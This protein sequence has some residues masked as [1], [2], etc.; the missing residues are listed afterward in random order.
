MQPNSA[1]QN[2]ALLS[3]F[4]LSDYPLKHVSIRVPWHD[5]GWN[6]TVCNAPHL[7][8]A[9]AKLRRIANG[10][11]DAAEMSIAGKRLIDLPR[12]DWPCC[13]DESAAFMSPFEFSRTKTHPFAIRD[14][15]KHLRPTPQ[16]F[17]AFSAGAIPYRWLMRERIDHLRQQLDLD[18]DMSREPSLNYQTPWWHE[19]NNQAALLNGFADHLLPNDS[20]CLFYAKHLPFVEGAV[21]ALIGVGRITG[22]GGITEYE[23]AS[24]GMR[25]M[26]WERPVQHS[27]R[28]T[29]VA[30]FL[31]P[32]HEIYGRFADDPNL[33][34]E[35]YTAHAPPEHWELFSYGS[36]LVSHD[37]AISTLLSIDG[38]LERIESDLGIST[39]PQR[40]W[41]QDELVRLWKV[42]GPFPGLGAVLRAFGLSRGLFV[43]QALQEIAGENAD[44]WPYA[45]AAFQDPSAVL[46]PEL[47]TDIGEL[48]SAWLQLPDERRRFLQLLARFELTVDQAKSLYDRDAR[49]KKGWA[50]EDR[51][52]LENPYR[53]Y[54]VSRFDWEG[55]SV[56]TVDR[57]VFPEQIVRAEHPLN[58]PS[59]LDSAVDP[60]RVRALTIS[61]LEASAELGH[62][63]GFPGDLAG[64][65]Q[66]I[67]GQPECPATS[68]N[69]SA[70]VPEMT[71]EVVAVDNGNESALQLGRYRTIGDLVRRQVL[72]RVKG[73]RHVVSANW[74]EL[75]A[76]KF[77]PAQDATEIRAQKEKAAALSELAESRFTALAGPAGSGK[78]SVLDILCSQIQDEDFLLLAPT[79]RARVRLQELAGNSGYFA[80]TVAQFLIRCGRY[81][82]R[83]GRYHLS[84][85]PK[86]SGYGTVIVDEASMLTEDML[87]GIFD[88]LTGVNRF[89]LIGDPAQLPPI[90]A[91]RPFFDIIAKLRPQDNE[92]KFPRVSEGYAELTVERRQAGTDRPDLLLARWFGAASPTPGDDDI[93]SETE[94][95]HPRLRFV[96]WEKPEDFHIKLEEVLG[97]ELQLSA[98]DEVRS[99]NE[100]LGA[101][102]KGD[103]DYFNRNM[104]VNKV[105]AWQILSPLR[106]MP[107]G[108]ENINRQIH[109][110]FRADYLELASRNRQRQIP[111]PMG[112][113]RIV[114]GDKVINVRNHRR[115][116]IYP[117]NGHAFKYLA[118]GEVG[119]AVGQWRSKNMKSAPWTLK[120]E[121]ASQPGYTYD[122]SS[123]DFS[124][125]SE[126]TL[127]L[128]YG[129]TV[130]KAQG[131]QFKVVIFV[132]PKGHPVL[133]RELVYTA[134][135][136]HEDRVVVMHQG[137]RS[138]LKDLSAPHASATASRRTNLLADCRM[139]KV[140][141]P[142]TARS[143]FLEAGLIHRTSSGQMV[144]S[145]SELLIAEALL[146]EGVE[147][148]YEKPLTL[149]GVTRYPDFTVEDDISGRRIYWE[150]LGMLDEESYR[151]GWERKLAWY[152][153]NGIGLH[154]VDS[155]AT[156]VLVTTTD[157]A[158]QGL[159]MAE[160]KDLIRSVCPV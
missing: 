24:D 34:V 56:S 63:L 98:G 130:H 18:V 81:D 127:E 25:A 41:V 78:T 60:R 68:D 100:S 36:E 20:L 137:P 80:Q 74:E 49:N 64:D 153:K 145:K 66:E 135:T 154:D 65:I 55:I 82:G 121:F 92:T 53:I 43:A 89:I 148:E 73:R 126:A 149:G 131:S 40:Q 114:Y 58:S 112:D 45:D 15:Y 107:F 26:V 13:V 21:R 99:F 95:Q 1:T 120:V 70:N 158:A 52:I 157:S 138:A 123:R 143:V 3:R 76:T 104:A 147:F 159:N 85:K 61:V 124:A 51:E 86:I 37:V 94:D 150:H 27:V 67:S 47:R 16:R 156:D 90:G 151:I 50:S 83:S 44:P 75:V 108:V 132:L 119:I 77:G 101:T 136:R 35:L 5:A 122:F 48:S 97:K 29:A 87:G 109:E 142:Q 141:I 42:R 19:G 11:D 160:I 32:Y 72:G 33:D 59:Q 139:V 84:D 111:E 125:E 17:P 54:E 91:G 152:R 105:T 129:L 8:S 10:K 117:D 28:S 128:A 30:G 69:I 4:E 14:H 102:R 144:R 140:D 38:K 62:T 23:R 133:T 103:Y 71:P 2:T 7:N 96:Q 155:D 118:N 110:R 79:G 22:I 115:D 12:A 88:A 9:C 116:N 113:E 31:M 106:G 46:P 146:D 6:G 39:T 93:F 57:G 134:L